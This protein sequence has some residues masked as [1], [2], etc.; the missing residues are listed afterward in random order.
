[1]K[2]AN[3]RA[4]NHYNNE[5]FTL[6]SRDNCN[7]PFYL[8]R[9]ILL[10]KKIELNTPD[11]NHGKEILFEIHIDNQNI[12]SKNPI[13][14]FLWEPLH[15]VFENVKVYNNEKNKNIYTWNDNLVLKKNYKK[16]N[17]PVAF[18]FNLPKRGFNEREKFCCLI[19]G[20]KYAKVKI[21]N[22]LYHERVKTIKWFESN[23]LIDLDLYG[24]GWTSSIKK[25][26]FVKKVLN[27]IQ[28]NFYKF[29]GYKPYPSY[30]GSIKLKSDVLG[31]YKFSICYE[32]SFE[33]GYI[34][35][36][37]FDC[38]MSG[39][40]PIYWGA[41]NIEDYVP[42]TCFIDRR[43]FKSHQELYNFMK[44]IDESEYL[45]YQN[46]ITEFLNSKL[47]DKFKAEIFCENI[48]RD[49]NEKIKLN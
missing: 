23:Y 16:F 32:N 19:A 36:K 26:N 12:L 34:T 39:C 41:P 17:L 18:N 13:F 43:K 35:E 11:L 49:I 15:V 14:I 8:L 28:K 37:I 25:N 24:S 45:K 22:D 21:F 47:I 6:N 7:Y 2:F 33:Y 20:N 29:V 1:M 46:S 10:S 48:I 3:F 44:N 27:T 40:V 5:C 9:E 30:K 4:T 31:N 38:F 42:K